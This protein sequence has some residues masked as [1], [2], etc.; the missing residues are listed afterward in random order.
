[1]VPSNCTHSYIT[2]IS[3][4]MSMS[5]TISLR[6]R[7]RIS[8]FRHGPAPF[9]LPAQEYHL[10]DVSRHGQLLTSVDY[11]ASCRELAFGFQS[12]RLLVGS[13]FWCGSAVLQRVAVEAVQVER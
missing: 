9:W 5:I 3:I 10:N 7:I 12:Q 1:M 13:L 2:S 4:S 11:G 8:I 6:V